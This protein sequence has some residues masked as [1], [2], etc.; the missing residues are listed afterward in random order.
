VTLAQAW[1]RARHVFQRLGPAGPLALIS[2]SLP[3]VGTVILLVLLKKTDI[4]PWLK[5]QDGVG[6]ALYLCGYM[7]LAGL[8]LCNTYAPSLV[9]GFAFGVLEGSFGAVTGVSLAAVLGYLGVRRVSGDRMTSLIA[10][11]PKWK[12]VQDALIGKSWMR[13]LLVVTLVRFSSSPFAVTNF[14]FASTRVHPLLYIV[15]TTV[16]I[17]PRTIAAVAIGA[18]LSTWDPNASSRWLIVAGIIVTL[19]VLAVLGSIANQAVQKVTQKQEQVP[20]CPS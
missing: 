17:A 10:E 14:V 4:A 9:G 5:A 1:D 15:G 7:L 12:A 20:G 18:S 11:Q 6:M 3:A 19:V 2:A 13:T 8:A 16:G